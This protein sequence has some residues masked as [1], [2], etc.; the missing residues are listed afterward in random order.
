MKVNNQQSHVS[1]GYKDLARMGAILAVGTVAIPVIALAAAQANAS[2]WGAAM[3]I[4]G[5]IECVYGIIGLVVFATHRI[6]KREAEKGLS[7]P[8]ELGEN[9]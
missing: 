2:T 8:Q 7:S 1:S 9:S 4:F 3:T 6:E 5:G